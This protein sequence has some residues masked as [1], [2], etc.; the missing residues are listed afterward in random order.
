MKEY[1]IKLRITGNETI[2]SGVLCAMC[3]IAVVD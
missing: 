3:A 2:S 1:Q